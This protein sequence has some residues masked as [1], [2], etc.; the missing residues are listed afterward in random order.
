MKQRSLALLAR[1]ALVACLHNIVPIA[2]ALL[3]GL[4]ITLVARL[5]LLT[6]TQSYL[7]FE[8]IVQPIITAVLYALV[9]P[10]IPLTSTRIHHGIERAWAV[11]LLDFAL[12]FIQTLAVGSI[13]TNSFLDALLGGILLSATAFLIF[14]D[15]DAVI[16]SHPTLL[17]LIPVALIRSVRTA[18]Q[19]GIYLRAYFILILQLAIFAAGVALTGALSHRVSADLAGFIVPVA[20]GLATLPLMATF[21]ALVYAEATAPRESAEDE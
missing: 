20:V 18:S 7:L 13:Q 2:I 6:D 12:S 11:I 14:A 5:T 21:T 15:V 9:S 1:D 4:A 10:R 17:G 19:R 8:L 16:G 3:G